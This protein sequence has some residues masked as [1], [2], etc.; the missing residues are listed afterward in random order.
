MPRLLLM[1][2]TLISF[3]ACATAATSASTDSTGHDP[4]TML[5]IGRSNDLVGVASSA[6]QGFVGAEILALRPM[7]R[8]G[9][10]LETVPGMIVTQHSGS[11]KSNQMFLRGFNLDHGTDFRTEVEGMPVN[12][13]TNA[14]GQG[15]TDLNFV[16]PEMVDHVDF[17]KGV[18]YADVSDFSGA[19][20][21]RLALKRR[22]DRNFI[23]LES[24][25]FAHRRAVTG[26]SHKLGSGHLL[27]GGELHYYDGPWDLPEDVNKINGMARYTWLNDNEDQEFS[28]LA[29]AYDNA[30]D[31]TDQVPQRAID[32]GLISPLGL[33]DPTNGGAASRY[34][35]SGKWHREGENQQQKIEFYGYRYK[36]Q[37]FSNF[38]Y[39]LDD[40]SQGD[41]FE[42]FGKRTVLGLQAEH[43]WYPDWFGVTNYGRIG[44]Q[45]RSDIIGEVSLHKTRQRQRLST[46]RSDEVFQTLNGVFAELETEWA[47]QWRSVLGVRLD[48]YYFDVTSD[49]E[50]NSGDANSTLASPK[51]SLAWQAAPSLEV[52]LN[53]GF[54]FHSND[55]RGTTISIDP[56]TNE[57]AAKVDPMVRA[58]G[59]ELG[60]RVM[61]VPNGHSTFSLW[62]LDLD[63]E[64]LYVGDAGATE[65]SDGS[66]RYGIELANFFEP[67]GNLAVDLD[68]SFSEARLLDVPDDRDRIPGALENVITAGVTWRSENGLFCS[69]RLRHLGRYPLVEDDSVRASATNLVNVG[70]GYSFENI[71]LGLDLLNAF[72]SDD[73]DIQYYYA[74]R[75]AGDPTD[76]VQDIHVHPVEPRSVRARL[77]GRF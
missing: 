11:G 38:T 47:P 77:V 66:R 7:L 25:E 8:V 31:S 2:M 52:Y 32:S 57:P 75:L 22:M 28:L 19:G 23:R 10:L 18:Y 6:S 33:I 71:E 30:W 73:N 50:E 68:L 56:A 70:L 44:F 3:A 27:V 67:I 12:L 54:G 29:M 21:A 60:L 72:D 76:G 48:N 35:L 53:G 36:M 20:S 58:T 5:V 24:G 69:G 26:I 16:I 15:Y 1:T 63:S 59:A 17:K 13:P 14:H 9:E 46:V 55:A 40:P 4:E 51:F 39:L 43:Q 42:Q 41:Q 61:P 45:S 65:A 34:S 37:L 62:W 49:R 74:S 64:L